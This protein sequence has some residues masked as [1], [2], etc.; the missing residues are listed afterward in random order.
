M[1]SDKTEN[2]ATSLGWFRVCV[3]RCVLSSRRPAS[4]GNTTGTTTNRDYLGK[5]IRNSRLLRLILLLLHITLTHGAPRL[6]C[7]RTRP[8]FLS[9]FAFIIKYVMFGINDRVRKEGW[10]FLK[11]KL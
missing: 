5:L 2:V 10:D 1:K 4:E 3:Y 8:L 9:A 7:I 6:V 11:R